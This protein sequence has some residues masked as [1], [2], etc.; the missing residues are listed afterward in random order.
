M[1]DKYTPIDTYNQIMSQNHSF[2]TNKSRVFPANLVLE[3]HEQHSRWF[4]TS[5]VTSV[6]LTGHAPFKNLKTQGLLVDSAGNKLSNSKADVD[7]TDLIEGTIKMSG[8]RLHGYGI[9]TM[10]AWAIRNDSDKNL[11]VIVDDI[12]SVNKEVKSIRGLLRI[13]LNNVNVYDG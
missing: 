2:D 8:E 7:P 1:I 4:L 11:E 3:N 12:E 9:D 13:L 6:A 10:R 5:L